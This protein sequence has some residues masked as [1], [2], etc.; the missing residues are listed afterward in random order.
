[1]KIACEAC[2]DGTVWASRYG[3]ND[4]DVWATECADCCGRGTVTAYCENCDRDAR[5]AYV[6]D[7]KRHY[8]CEPCYRECRT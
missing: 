8:W 6:W 3:G 7:G 2:E 5:I 4:P 1:M